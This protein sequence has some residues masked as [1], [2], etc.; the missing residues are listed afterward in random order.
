MPLLVS[1]AFK[2][3]LGNDSRLLKHTK[4]PLKSGQV[5][6]KT[7]IYSLRIN[8]SAIISTHVVP[9]LYDFYKF[10]TRSDFDRPGYTRPRW[11]MNGINI[12]HDQTHC[13][14]DTR[15]W[16]PRAFK[17]VNKLWNI[18]KAE[19]VRDF[20]QTAAI[21]HIEC[22]KHI[23]GFLLVSQLEFVPLQ[24]LWSER[25][26]FVSGKLKHM[27]AGVFMNS[28]DQYPRHESFFLGQKNLRLD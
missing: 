19:A 15:F 22:T 23:K 27:G 3:F 25:V 14:S 20:K 24:F 10:Y 7:Y 9:N 21:S 4:R 1:L 16:N 5:N 28:N 12:L 6:K 2:R 8:D 17:H 13:P 18:N 11:K 26:A